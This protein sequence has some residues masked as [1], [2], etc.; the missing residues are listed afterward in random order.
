MRIQRV[1]L[2]N[3]GCHEQLDMH[4]GPGLNIIK[5]PNGSGKSTL[6]RALL[7]LL[8]GKPSRSQENEKDRAWASERLYTLALD[9]DVDGRGVGQLRKDFENNLCR[10]VWQDGEELTKFADVD[11]ALKK[12]MHISS[13]KLFTNTLFVAQQELVAVSAGKEITASLEERVTGGD[14]EIT[15]QK[16]LDRLEKEIERIGRGYSTRAI[17]RLGPIAAAQKE[18]EALEAKIAK[19]RQQLAQFIQLQGRHQEIEEQLATIHSEFASKKEFAGQIE[20]VEQLR[21][22]ATAEAESEQRLDAQL[23]AIEQAQK[24]LEAGEKALS[25]LGPVSQLE[26]SRHQALH[27]LHSQMELLQNPP[28]PTPIA[29]PGKQPIG[30]IVLLT[31]GLVAVVSG[32]VLLMLQ[33]EGFWIALAA[34][35]VGLFTLLGGAGWWMM[36]RVSRQSALS[37]EQ[38]AQHHA[39]L[40]MQQQA[41]A[42]SDLQQALTS[43]DCT[44]WQDYLTK[45]AAVASEKSRR[46]Q[47]QAKLD[48][49]LP[50]GKSRTEIENRRRTA[51]LAR[52]DA[53]ETLQSPELQPAMRVAPLAYQSLLR[54]IKQLEET[55]TNLARSYH[56]LSGRLS[57]ETVSPTELS[58]AEEQKEALS[59]KIDHDKELLALYQRTQEMLQRAR[60][61]TIE[62]VRDDLESSI[63]RHF[64]H[65]TLEQYGSVKIDPELNLSVTIAEP[66]ER[67]TMPQE[68]SCGTQDQLYFAMRLAL[69]DN[70][71][72]EMHPPLFLDD[73]F[74]TFDPERRQAAMQLCTGL[75]A[76]RQVFLFTCSDDY[77]EY[78]NVQSLQTP[79]LFTYASQMQNYE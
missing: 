36:Q 62:R 35:T 34:L 69:V 25:A 65:L 2:Q 37:K 18:Q 32:I 53:A 51:S 38:Q 44:S 63:S 68:L 46:E 42:Q 29:H 10:L 79:E 12:L 77:D 20:K 5:G 8:F 19:L 78:G 48:A 66:V 23:E 50:K 74:V 4:F 70:L 61:Q 7:K 67:V 49:L 72:P 31:I 56:E 11:R 24:A 26:T 6:Q 21:K 52:R 1:Q 27:R 71:W 41:K 3:F 13:D 45:Q 76:Y 9:L 57:A 30:P 22:Q 73:P 54:E 58:L 59:Q 33:P 39:A 14:A 55:H 15:T 43:I 40:Q 28:L 16:V 17:T 75:A 47:A 60:Q 64:E